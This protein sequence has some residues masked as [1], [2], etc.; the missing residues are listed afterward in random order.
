[1]WLQNIK[2]HEKIYTFIRYDAGDVWDGFWASV[3]KN[4][5]DKRS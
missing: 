4:F 3:V 2:H 5:V 1:M